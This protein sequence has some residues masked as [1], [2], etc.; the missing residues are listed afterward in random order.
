[1]YIFLRVYISMRLDVLMEVYFCGKWA[2][3]ESVS[4][5]EIVYITGVYI[6]E[7]VYL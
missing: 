7:S 6:S 4:F 5:K 1:M 2:F 3:T